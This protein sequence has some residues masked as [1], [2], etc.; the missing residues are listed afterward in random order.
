MNKFT[1]F[2][3][4]PQRQKAS[5]LFIFGLISILFSAHFYPDPTNAQR[6][7]AGGITGKVFQDY[8][9]NGNYDTS[10]GL[11][12][13]DAGTANVTVTA[14]DSMG[15]AR[16]TAVT[17]SN[18]NFSL[19]A[20]GTGPYRLEFAN[21]P[22][23]FVPSARSTNSLLGGSASNSGSTVQFVADG[24]TA[25]VNV[26]LSRTED[27]CQ[28]N[29]E[30]IISRFAEGAQNG[31]YGNNSVLINF[32]Y[33]AGTSYTDTTIANYDNP[34]SH[35]ISLN[36][37]SVGT[38]FSLAYSRAN[39]RVYAA[40]YFKKH[41]GFGPGADGVFNTT[42]DPGAIYV[43]NPSNNTVTSVFTVPNATTNSHNTSNYGEDNLD[44]G[45]NAVGRTSL[46]GMALADDESRLFVINLQNRRLYALNP[47][48]GSSVGNSVQVSSLT[49]PTPGG[50]N[51]NCASGDI[52]PFAVKYYRGQVY[53]GMV[54]SAESTQATKDLFAYIFRVNPETLVFDATPLFSFP[55]DYPRGLADPGW[56]AE[57]KA[58]RSTISSNFV[59]PQPMFTTME[60][61]NGNLIIGLRDRAG[62][63]AF[64]NGPN[65]KRTA[66][67][68]LRAC[69]SFGSWTLESNGRC[70]GSGSAPQGTGQGV[71]NGE[72]Y[73]QDDFCSAPN[74]GNYH[75]EVSWG[76]LMY[77]P[78]R[79]HVLT[80]LLDPI[81]RKILSNG[82][83]DGGLRW[84]NNSTGNSDRA[85]RVYNGTGGANVPDFG[86]ANGL[87]GVTALCRAAPIEI[88]NR[89]WFD[90]NGNGVQ[91][92]QE[93]RAATSPP[94]SMS[95]VTV[96]LY[97][98]G[99]LLATAVTDQDGEYYFSSATGTNTA[100]A[101]YNLNLQ[102]NTSYQIRFDNPADYASGGKLNNLFLTLANSNFQAGEADSS[103]SDASMVTNPNGS[104]GG[105]FAVISLTT[106]A[107]G[108]ND[109]T[110]DAG[111]APA[112]RLYSLG[113]R[114]WIDINNNGRIDSGEQGMGN[115]S[116]SLYAD[117]DAD[118]Q[119]DNP[120]APLKTVN[121][122]STGHYRFDGL[123]AG[124][125]VVCVDPVNFVSGG[126][127]YGY[128]NTTGSDAGNL[129]TDVMNS[130]NG[131]DQ[132]SLT[133]RQTKGIFSR[134]KDLG[135][136]TSEPVNE[137][138]LG[139][140]GQGT[141]DSQAN[142]TVDFGFLLVPTAAQVSVE[143]RV[144]TASG[145]GI[146]GAIVTLT[147]EDGATRTVWT[148]A[149]GYYCF[150][151]VGIGQIITVGA[152]A[153]SYRFD[154][155]LRAFTLND[156]VE[157]LNFTANKAKSR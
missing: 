56:A 38:V 37:G 13:I 154:Q 153:R 52:R 81:D 116:V 157:N 114:V 8:N 106:G 122:D 71:G 65:A 83:F 148:N 138:D 34:S 139:A 85:Y 88:G 5:V 26:A 32:P 117:A 7:F 124:N 107:A 110:F 60:F 22:T 30:I 93:S 151:G 123:Q 97:A 133:E 100:N 20:A 118:G 12:S 68:T 48:T 112:P 9:S 41:A 33:T 21:L 80:T 145:R 62:D 134:T 125:Y 78:G 39:N 23:G 4:L 11:N 98:S 113:N 19:T 46:G 61:E 120:A 55:L 115:V 57:W 51:A 14:F 152:F 59:Y 127:L 121:T 54:C 27:Y 50:T 74:N 64:D 111:F 66:G 146:S 82:T 86:K 84:F 155:P 91:D 73:H 16:G 1:I 17:D 108:A 131:V 150:E 29:P 35:S 144:L 140:G 72:F 149:F 15:A 136:G 24:N 109:H 2:H 77:L 31:V 47:T 95:G 63:Q 75:D 90:A 130:E 103:D 119:P 69:G 36:A 92:P 44:T 28:N 25:N 147:R 70:G 42:D 96:R 76:V 58:W 79:Q 6:E 87:G 101:I 89:I 67:D 104:P 43:V 126:S 137:P 102:P 143:G 53:V 99:T 135:P 128:H 10:S 141:V 49:L 94:V 156:A 105:T 45:W 40:A 3:G 18:G 132:P 142:M 129:D